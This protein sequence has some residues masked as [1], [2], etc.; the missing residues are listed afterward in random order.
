MGWMFWYEG[1]EIVVFPRLAF[2]P[3]TVSGRDHMN[4]TI[5]KLTPIIDKDGM[6]G[7]EKC[8]GE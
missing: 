3:K 2:R 7:Q 4:K 8:L 5:A 6:I 1:G